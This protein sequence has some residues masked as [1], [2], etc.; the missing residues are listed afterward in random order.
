MKLVIGLGNPGL[1][2]K[3]TRHNVGFIILDNYINSEK[4]LKKYNSLYIV[5]D[6]IIFLKPLTYM[7][8]SGMD[9]QKFVNYY[10]V[11]PE[12]ILVIHD[13]LDILIGEYKLKNNSSSGGHN[14]IKSII[15]QLNTEK[16]GRLKIGIKNETLGDASKFVTSKFN[17]EEFLTLQENQI[18]FNKIITMFI[19][20][21]FDYT[22][23]NYKNEKFI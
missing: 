14:G 17:K 1:K 19:K 18:K 15:S 5:K 3:K 2:Y 16:F 13:D 20:E 4:W 22:V 21:G 12:N 10:K 6:D 9:V 8:L 11:K 23:K 7:N